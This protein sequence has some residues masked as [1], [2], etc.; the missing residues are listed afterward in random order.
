MKTKV[1]I[2]AQKFINLHTRY[3]SRDKGYRRDSERADTTAAEQIL[4]DNCK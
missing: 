3:F 1:N 2:K 4:A